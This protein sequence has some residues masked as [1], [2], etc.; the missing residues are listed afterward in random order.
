M[1]EKRVI[2]PS[3]TM[4]AMTFLGG[5]ASFQALV[6]PEDGARAIH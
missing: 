4:C 5:I 6:L 1:I 2:T 3:N